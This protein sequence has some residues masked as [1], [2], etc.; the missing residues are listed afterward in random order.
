[1]AA[2]LKHRTQRALALYTFADVD[3]PL[4]VAYSDYQIA[5]AFRDGVQPAK[6]RLVAELNL[7]RQ[8]SREME[9]AA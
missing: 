8:L 2:T 4:V 1:M 5:R 3:H 7:E 9:R 6:A